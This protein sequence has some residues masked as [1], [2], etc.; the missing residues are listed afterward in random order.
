M[1]TRLVKNN[2]GF[3][4][5]SG[6]LAHVSHKSDCPD[7]KKHRNPKVKLEALENMG[8]RQSRCMLESPLFG[9]DR[10]ALDLVVHENGGEASFKLL[11]YSVHFQLLVRC[12]H[13]NHLYLHRAIASYL[14]G[15][16]AYA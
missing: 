14:Q 7:A 8:A 10:V 9:L 15:A 2:F 5:E 16:H 4:R 1:H 11:R 6:W 13:V 12:A 3:L